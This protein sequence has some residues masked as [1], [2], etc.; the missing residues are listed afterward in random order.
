ME[1]RVLGR[2]REKGAERDVIG[3]LFARF[4]G[5]MARIVAGDADD[6]VAQRLAGIGIGGILLA[7]MDAVAAGLEGE[8]GA[9]VQQ[10]GDAAPLRRRAQHVHHATQIV[11]GQVLQ[12]DLDTGDVAG[13]QGGLP[14]LHPLVRIFDDRGGDQVQAAGIGGNGRGP[15]RYGSLAMGQDSHGG[16]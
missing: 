9:V 5:Q 15:L 8:V 7:D 16:G 4:H 13:I 11:V 3:P 2:G 14:R 12:A 1:F 10:N 6:A